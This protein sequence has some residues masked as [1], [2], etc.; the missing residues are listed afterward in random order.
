M[1]SYYSEF[2]CR[3]IIAI[4]I[5]FIILELA[6][7]VTDILSLI[8]VKNTFGKNIRNEI[9]SEHL[10][11]IFGVTTISYIIGILSI[12]IIFTIKNGD[13]SIF[14]FLLVIY[15]LVFESISRPDAFFCFSIAILVSFLLNIVFNYC[16]V[17]KNISFSKIKRLLSSLIISI[18][19]APF[20]FYISLEGIL[21]F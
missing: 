20:L 7:L 6:L 18:F 2:F 1:D 5:F 9:T 16:I 12:F 15:R 21:N 19:T 3:M 8:V 14:T 11:K 10:K 13:F 17:L 4:L